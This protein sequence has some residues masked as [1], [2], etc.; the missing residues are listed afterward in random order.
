M[1]QE[2]ILSLL[3]ANVLLHPLRLAAKVEQQDSGAHVR[4]KWSQSNTKQKVGAT[5]SGPL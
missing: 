4:H 3:C 2:I 1:R 5:G